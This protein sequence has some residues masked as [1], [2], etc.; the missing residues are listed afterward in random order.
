MIG[1]IIGMIGIALLIYFLAWYFG[2]NSSL[3]SYADGSAA[4]VI[5]ATSISDA[6]SAVYSYS[7]WIYVSEWST[8]N[9]KTIFRRDTNNPVMVLRKFENAIDTTV[10]LSSGIQ[11]CSVPN[12]PLQKWTNIIITVNNQSL[13][14]Y[15]NGKLVKTC[16]LSSFPA[17]VATENA[18]VLLT[19]D[20]GFSGYTARFKYWGDSL[21]P[22]EAWNVYKA[23]PGGNIFTNFFGT[24]KLQMNFIKGTE[25]KASI[26]I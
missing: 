21:N 7:I 23:G 14:T 6:T 19:P 13:D 20:G 26:T 5:P 1:L 11:T 16:V 15:V 18:N 8:T 2:N 3:S 10:R 12:I 25:T 9:D 17:T 22:Q 24:Y 4:L